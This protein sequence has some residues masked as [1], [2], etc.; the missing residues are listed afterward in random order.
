L[1]NKI[2]RIEKNIVYSFDIIITLFWLLIGVIAIFFALNEF[3]H[4]V[5]I[6][7]SFYKEVIHIILIIFIYIEIISMVKKYFEE[8]HHFPK[9]YLIYIA[10]T[11]LA[12][13]IIGDMDHAFIY[14]LSV[15]VLVIAL[16]IITISNKKYNLKD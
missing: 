11:A 6:Y 13:H 14:S 3:I 16:V 4:L 12:R 10:I 7:N 9:R 15:L 2:D 8:N 1:E 5:S